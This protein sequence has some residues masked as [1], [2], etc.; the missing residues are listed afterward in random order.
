MPPK[1][2]IYIQSDRRPDERADLVGVQPVFVYDL[3]LQCG[4]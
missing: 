2:P 1:A 4:Q 3:M